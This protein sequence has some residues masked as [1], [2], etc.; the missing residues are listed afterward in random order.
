M[1]R[2]QRSEKFWRDVVAGADRSGL[3]RAKYAEKMGIGRA[4]LGYWLTKL[5]SKPSRAVKERS[6]ALVPVRVLETRSLGG[7]EL[8][9]EFGHCVLR[10]EEG[11]SVDYVA[12][13]AAALRSC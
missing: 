4:A 1:K 6:Q 2:A 3:T 10:F 12:K 7:R 11:T 9:L 5:G 13:L 8:A